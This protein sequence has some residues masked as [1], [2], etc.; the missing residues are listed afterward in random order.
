M[1]RIVKIGLILATA[2]VLIAAKQLAPAH[3]PSGAA[4]AAGLSLSPGDMMRNARPLPET[5]VDSFI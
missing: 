5:P 2:A 3:A 1:T 4:P